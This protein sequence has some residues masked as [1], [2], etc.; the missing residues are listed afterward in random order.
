M[1]GGMASGLALIAAWLLVLSVGAGY[2]AWSGWLAAR[3]L[4]ARGCRDG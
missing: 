3:R 2:W 1:N 4:L